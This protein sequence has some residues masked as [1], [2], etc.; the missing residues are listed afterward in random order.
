CCR[1]HGAPQPTFAFESQMDIIARELGIDPMEL[2]LKNAVSE[3]Y[4]GPVG[5]RYRGVGLKEVLLKATERIDLKR[6]E[7]VCR[8]KGIAVGNWYSGSGSSSAIMKLN[9]D[10]TV[11]LSIGAPD[12]TGTDIMALQVAAEELDLPLDRLVLASKDTDHAPFDTLSSGSRITH[13]IGQAVKIASQEIKTKIL[14]LAAQALDDRPEHL[15][16]KDGLIWS[17]QYPDKPLSLERIARTSHFRMHGPIMAS[18]TY[19]G[20]MGAFDPKAVKGF[21]F[22]MGEDRT[23]VAQAVEVEV[24][25]ETGTVSVLRLVSA[26]DVGFLINPPNAENQVSGGVHQG[27]G[28]ALSEEVKMEAGKVLNPNFREYGIRYAD[29]MPRVEYCFI[30]NMNGPGPYGAKG[31]GEQPGIPTAAAVANAIYDAVGVRIKSI[32]ITPEKILKELREK[33]NRLSA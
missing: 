5:G 33:E 8:G 3:G 23:F 22:D 2:R 6:N 13:C 21:L 32:P 24:D 31:L 15:E 12:A 30:E 4:V 14:A 16:F 11:T 17:R 29:D 28:Y 7:G 26:N 19:F 25:Q 18:G 1:A 20:R 9:E 10:G 27:L